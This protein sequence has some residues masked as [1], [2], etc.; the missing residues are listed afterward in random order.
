MDTPGYRVPGTPHFLHIRASDSPAAIVP[1]II[2][3]SSENA[4]TPITPL[5]SPYWPSFSGM[6]SVGLF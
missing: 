6:L 2:A 4:A 3:R 5:P 1:E